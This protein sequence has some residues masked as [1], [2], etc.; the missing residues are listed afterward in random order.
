MIQLNRKVKFVSGTT[1]Y[2][3]FKYHRKYVGK[4]FVSFWC[5]NNRSANI[6]CSAKLKMS[7]SGTIFDVKGK[8]ADSCYTKAEEHCTALGIIDL[9]VDQNQIKKSKD[10]T[11]FVLKHAEEICLNN[12]S[13]HPKKNFYKGIGRD[14]SR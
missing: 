13:L 1:Y 10:L 4:R 8:H 9:N 11:D 3:G 14:K 2:E 5:C 7:S 12:L 6:K